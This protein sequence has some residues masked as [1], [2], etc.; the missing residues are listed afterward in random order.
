MTDA[1]WLLVFCDAAPLPAGAGWKERLLY[2]GLDRLAPGFRHV[3]ALRE[4]DAFDGWIMVN[5]HSGG[6]DVVEVP[7]DGVFWWEGMPVLGEQWFDA[8]FLAAEHGVTHLVTCYGVRRMEFL[9]RGFLT[10]V[11]VVK[12]LLGENKYG[13]WLTPWQLYHGLLKR[14]RVAM[15]GVFGGGGGSP[16]TSAADAERERL[17]Q[18]KDD[19]K[20][21][22]KAKADNMKARQGG[23]RGSLL[24][25]V[26]AA[27]EQQPS[28][29]MGG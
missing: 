21:R 2:W 6:L 28:D 22:N 24:D 26:G 7:R 18:E 8:L 5:P 4:A 13:T 11:S 15:G 10:C 16:D 17:R 9:P 1:L 20:R 27:G 19:L 29:K 3:F 12:H 14:R 25:F 23:G